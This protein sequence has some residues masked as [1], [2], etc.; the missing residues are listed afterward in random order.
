MY[1]IILWVISCVFRIYVLNVPHVP[2]VTLH[3]SARVPGGNVS[4]DVRNDAPT[5]TG[6]KATFNIDLRFPTNQ[7]VLP[8]GQVVWA[9]NCT[10]DGQPFSCFLR[11]YPE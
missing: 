9:R 1:I 10:V 7:S 5:L 6:A 11:F 2:H 8:G 4:F 3:G